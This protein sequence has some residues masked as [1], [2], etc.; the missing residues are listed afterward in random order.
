MSHDDIRARLAAVEGIEWRVTREPGEEYYGDWLRV[1][2]AML[3]TTFSP[4]PRDAATTSQA[5]AVGDFIQHAAADLH[6]LLADLDHATATRAGIMPTTNS[7]YGPPP[8]LARGEAV[9]YLADA[10]EVQRPNGDIVR[11]DLVALADAAISAERAVAGLRGENAEL[12]LRVAALEA[13][14]R[15]AERA[16]RILASTAEEELAGRDG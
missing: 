15:R 3:M 12:R 8:D 11:M 7:V 9:R 1:G 2:P 16:G 14:A 5:E 13:Q 10:V 6:R 4:G